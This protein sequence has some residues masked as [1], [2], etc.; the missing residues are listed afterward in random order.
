M[1]DDLYQKNLLRHAAA[2][3]GHGRLLKPHGTVT[4][5]NP[6]CG[7]RVT[8]DV[9]L[10]NRLISEVAQ[11]VRACVLCQAAASIIGSNAVD[12][13]ES[14]IQSIVA[15]T[16]DMLH[17]TETL[18]GKIWPE[19]EAFAPVATHSSRHRCVLL[20]F[21]AL[22]QAIKSATAGEDDSVTT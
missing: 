13:S 11:V 4:L 21:E 5:D 18:S 16:K 14:D 3:I 2:S 9:K 20:P 12:K 15:A 7:D 6:L 22:L 8:I 10:K 1:V 17:S 19:M